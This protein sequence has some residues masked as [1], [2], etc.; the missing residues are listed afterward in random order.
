MRLH[1]NKP[2]FQDEVDQQLLHEIPKGLSESRRYVAVLVDE[3]KV[4]EGLVFSKHSGEIIGFTNLGNIND[5]LLRLETGEQPAVAKQ[6]LV[7]MVRGLLF[8]LEFPYAH[9]GTR[10]VTADVLFSILWE[11]IHRLEAN[12]LKVLCVTAN[13]AIPN[14]KF[15]RMHY[16]KKDSSTYLYKVRNVYSP[17]NRWLYFVSDPPHL[18]KTIRNCWSLSGIIHGTHHM[19]MS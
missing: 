1:K 11:A 8:K 9:F 10:G 3:M 6:I 16:V 4:K 14:R 12:E 17:E 2:G 5:E 15:F 19:K 18:I 7:L 13:G